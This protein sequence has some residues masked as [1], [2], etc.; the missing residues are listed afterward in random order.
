MEETLPLR[1]VKGYGSVRKKPEGKLRVMLPPTAISPPTLGENANVA[2]QPLLFATRS[3]S[4][5]VNASSL[6][7]LPMGPLANVDIPMVFASCDVVT[8]TEL[9]IL[10]VAL[11][12][13][14]P[15]NVT[16]NA[17]DALTVPFW[18]V[19]T[20]KLADCEVQLILMLALVNATGAEDGKKKFAG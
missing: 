6:T 19:N 5:T 3:H 14:K 10:E 7:R 11:P 12:M 2:E 8:L 17:V 15:I 13:V 18:T 16:N 4:G 9:G 1:E 20:I